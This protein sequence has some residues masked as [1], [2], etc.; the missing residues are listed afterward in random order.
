[1][2]KLR[3]L[4]ETGHTE[5]MVSVEEL[6]DQI[7]EH[8]SHWVSLNGEII[9]RKTVQAVNWENIECVDLIPAIVGGNY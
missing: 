1:M 4:N 8:P 5:L 9:E 6:I 2:M 3:I 7:N